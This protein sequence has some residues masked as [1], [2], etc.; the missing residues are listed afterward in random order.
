MCGVEG[1]AG[2]AGRDVI[3]YLT[4]DGA[5]RLTQ[6]DLEQSVKNRNV[7]QCLECAN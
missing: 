3:H 1:L 6:H 5:I 7:Q 2:A 4:A